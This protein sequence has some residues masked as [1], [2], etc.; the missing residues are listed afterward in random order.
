MEYSN[1][2]LE[3]NYLMMLALGFPTTASRAARLQFRVKH[4]CR[5]TKGGPSFCCIR[6]MRVTLR[7]GLC[8]V[9]SMMCGKRGL[10]G[11]HH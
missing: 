2:D 4:Q 1:K 9:V 7:L 6:E 3:E 11:V 10:M 5:V 8:E